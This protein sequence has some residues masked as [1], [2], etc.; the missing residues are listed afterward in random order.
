MA[1]SIEFIPL[2]A[3]NTFSAIAGSSWTFVIPAVTVG[4]VGQ[5]A[6]DIILNNLPSAAHIGRLNCPHVLPFAGPSPTVPTHHSPILTPVELYSVAQAPGSTTTFIVAQQ[7]SPL[8]RGRAGD[9]ARDLIAWAKAAGASAVVIVGGANAA[10]RR[11]AEIRGSGVGGRV[12][13][14]ATSSSGAGDGVGDRAAWL[15]QA[16]RRCG[17]SEIDGG[18]AGN[19]RGWLAG[20]EGL[21]GEGERLGVKGRMAGFLPT[22][23]KG[24]F[25]RECLEVCEKEAV[26]L[27]ALLMFVHEGDNA[28][29]AC[30]LASALSW[31][32]EI[33][34]S[35]GEDASKDKG[36]NDGGGFGVGAERLSPLE[37]S[38]GGPLMSY[39]RKWKAPLVWQQTVDAPIGLY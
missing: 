19:G 8:A 11:D 34:V 6:V 17:W 12:R 33:V 18:A 31:M 2:T 13:F 38:D 3:S 4:N 23:R 16:V 9:H 15:G 29:D 27:V 20:E 24:A 26:P 1:P 39:L 14:A 35:D 5:L 22:S 21:A 37:D 7:R 25:V 36:R 10:G 32:L 28:A 30:V